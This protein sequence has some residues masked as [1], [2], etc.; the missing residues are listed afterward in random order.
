MAHPAELW[1]YKH[2]FSPGFKYIQ[3]NPSSK[4]SVYI[5]QVE[6]RIDQGAGSPAQIGEDLFYM[7][8][9][10]NGWQILPGNVDEKSAEMSKTAPK[11][12]PDPPWKHE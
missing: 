7:I 10:E 2:P 4:E 1:R 11:P 5:V 9:S 6:I 12:L 3:T 8:Q